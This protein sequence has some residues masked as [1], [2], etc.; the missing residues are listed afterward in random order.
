VLQVVDFSIANFCSSSPAHGSV[1]P[2]SHSVLTGVSVK[3]S[4]TDFS[5]L[6]GL[7]SAPFRGPDAQHN[8]TVVPWSVSSL[9]CFNLHL[10]RLSVL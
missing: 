8:C 2:Q 3:E 6:L 9:T 4:T 7:C 10:L 1:L 5:W